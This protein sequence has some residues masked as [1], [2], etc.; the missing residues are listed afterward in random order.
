MEVPPGHVTQATETD[1]G[2]QG[3]PQPPTGPIQGAFKTLRWAP[4]EDIWIQCCSTCR[5]RSSEGHK[6]SMCPIVTSEASTG[7]SSVVPLREIA[8]V[9]AGVWI[10]WVSPCQCLPMATEALSALPRTVAKAGWGAAR[11]LARAVI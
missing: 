1:R 7:S 9:P 11:S 2:I 6:G 5:L 10:Q 3:P 8:V 4:A